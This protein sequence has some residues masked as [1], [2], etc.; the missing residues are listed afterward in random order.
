MS[1]C[2]TYDPDANAWSVAQTMVKQRAGL[3]L[4]NINDVLFAVGGA[5]IP[6]ANKWYSSFNRWVRV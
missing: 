3:S 4:V 2:E 5:Y 6:L 1:G